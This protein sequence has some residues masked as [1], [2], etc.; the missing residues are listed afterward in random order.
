M[1]KPAIF[2]LGIS[3]LP[4]AQKLKAELNGE[5]HTPDCVSG[6]DVSYAKAT[7]HLA[8]LFQQGQTI[9]GLCASGILIRAIAPH[10]NDKRTEPPVIAVAEDGSSV[11]PLLGGHHGANALAAQIA[12]ITGG[13]AAITTASEV[14]FGFAF[15]EA[16]RRL[17]PCQSR[18]HE[19][20]HRCAARRRAPL[21]I[22][23]PGESRDPELPFRHNGL[24]QLNLVPW[25]P[26]FAGVTIEISEKSIPGGPKHL[27][28][29]PHT[30]TIGVGCERGTSPEEVSRPH[31]K[32]F[33]SQ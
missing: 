10:L 7:A 18:R 2:I 24:G 15:D 29:H 28:Y 20:R 19:I 11:V 30:L 27:I 25:A 9:I 5:I 1:V 33:E 3:A 16:L 6:G 17:Y 31:R 22:C 13:H 4:L 32:H 8:Q 21:V 23:Y 12:K 14:R 26:A